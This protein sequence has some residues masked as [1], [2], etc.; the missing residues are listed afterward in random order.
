[1]CILTVDLASR[2]TYNVFPFQP[3]FGVLGESWRVES[4][5]GDWVLLLAIFT[6]SGPKGLNK[7]KSKPDTEASEV[8]EHKVSIT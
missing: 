7:K 3:K 8:A 1:M 5:C 4:G 6:D 2:V